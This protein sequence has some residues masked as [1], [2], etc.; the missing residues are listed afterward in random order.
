MILLPKMDIMKR[1]RVSTRLK[2]VLA[3][4]EK[5]NNERTLVWQ[6]FSCW[7]LLQLLNALSASVAL[8]VIRTRVKVAN[9]FMVSRCVVLV[10]V[11][12]AFSFFM[13]Q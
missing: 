1:Q 5:S 6:G 9:K 12:K 3:S 13:R 8:R 4:R 10:G 2:A 11:A 7:L